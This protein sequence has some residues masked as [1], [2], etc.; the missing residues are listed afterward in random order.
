MEV[1]HVRRVGPRLGRLRAA[2]RAVLLLLFQKVAAKVV[3]LI[4]GAVRA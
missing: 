2:E 4:A 1:A 3:L